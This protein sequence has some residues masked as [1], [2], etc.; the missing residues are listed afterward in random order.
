[1]SGGVVYQGLCCICYVM[2]IAIPD[3][4][5]ACM[6]LFFCNKSKVMPHI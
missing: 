3:I 2:K 6:L 5:K 1:M 4:I